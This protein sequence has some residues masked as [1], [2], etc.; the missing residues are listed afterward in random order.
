[1]GSAVHLEL[2]SPAQS[3]AP[4][5]ENRPRAVVRALSAVTFLEW[6]GASVGLPLLPVY[7]EDRG[8]SSV[9]VGLV[10][11]AYFAAG[12]LL[13]Y[14]FG[15]LV[16]KVTPAPVLRAGL[17]IFAIG[18]LTLALPLTPGLFALSRLLQGAGAGA[19]E[20]AALAAVGAVVP[21]GQRGRA[22]ASI[23]GSQLAG[24]AIGPMVGSLIGAFSV[25]AVFIAGGLI[26]LLAWIPIALLRNRA[27][28]DALRPAAITVEDGQAPD[29]DTPSPTEESA[30]TASSMARR[31]L[32][33]SLLS[34]A[35]FGLTVGVY[36][37]CWTLLLTQRGAANWQVGLSWTLFALPFVI[38]S[39]PA[40]RLADA[41][42]RRY[43]VVISFSVALAC[44]ATYPFLHSLVTLMILGVVEAAATAVAIPA[45][46]SLLSQGVPVRR[47]GRAQGLFATSETATTAIAAG[48]SGSLFAV[49]PWLPFVG[50]AVIGILLIGMLP[51]IWAAVAGRATPTPAL[52]AQRQ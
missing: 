6:F 32:I 22:F 24:M 36:E 43:L 12:V 39:R 13:Q 23:Y 4:E 31:V 40:G 50:G 8:A 34:A 7:L 37:T 30:R 45:V 38:A 52:P 44:C 51:T 16:D 19:A 2:P 11:A 49:R 9:T 29:I 46:Q 35:A 1:M 28:A 42:D 21:A 27:G 47:L 20:V 10:V 33:G 3:A 5:T 25:T 41:V 48:I 17:V 15:R 14:V 18:G 26:S